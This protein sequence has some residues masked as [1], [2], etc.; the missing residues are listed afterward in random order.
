MTTNDF[1][2]QLA[3][4]SNA[5][6]TENGQYALKSTN[7]ALI[8]LF[9]TIGALRYRDEDEII[10]LFTKAYAEDRLLALKM[11]FYSRDILEG[12]GERRTFRTIINW[13]ADEE[14]DDIKKNI[15][16]IPKCGRW[17][18]M[19]SRVGTKLEK[20]AFAFMKAQFEEDIKNID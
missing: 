20:D 4:E 8:D 6:E 5:K 13:L 3:T 17:D 10:S 7:N 14:P 15:A 11:L 19:Y 9:G 16:L 12:L 18:D 1:I 2:K